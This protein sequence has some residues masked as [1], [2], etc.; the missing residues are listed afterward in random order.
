M[1]YDKA[2]R[3]IILN[4]EISQLDDFVISFC[5]NIK[6]YVVVS[7]YISIVF[8]RSRAT[9]DIDLLIKIKDGGEF[10]EIWDKLK[11]KGFECINTSN[12]SEAF[13]MLKDFAIRFSKIGKPIPNMEF[14]IVKNEID[15]YS[16]N[17][18]I[19]LQLK[20]SIIFISPIEMQIAYKLMLG[21]NGNEKDIEDAK[22]LY[23]LFKEN[24]E[25][26]ELENL[27]NKLGV[28]KEF[29]MIK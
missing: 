17:N 27:I 2:K 12:S 22:H 18:R 26:N 5:K 9:E 13:D 11:E 14:K 6:N 1:K 7:G 28:L 4:R 24:I 20:D 15:E 29:E 19:Q 8:G 23:E 3:T 16:L 25:Y 21:K 10:E